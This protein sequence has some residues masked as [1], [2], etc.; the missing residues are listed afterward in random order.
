MEKSRNYLF[1]NYKVFLILTVV[2]GHVINSSYKN[3]EFLFYLKWFISAFHMPAFIL[4]TGYFSKRKTDFITLLKR[5]IVPYLV[6][7]VLYYLLY[8]YIIHRETSLS[9]MYPKYTLWF[10]LAVFFWKL[11]TPYFT[12]IPGYLLISIIAGLCIGLSDNSG[13]LLSIARITVLYPFYLIGYKWDASTISKI[14]EHK[15][16]I[17]F[18]ALTALILVLIA[19]S[20]VL[21]SLPVT[22]TYARYNYDAL[23]QTAIEGLTLRSLFYIIGFLITVSLLIIMPSKKYWFSDI[24]KVTLQ[25]YLFHGMILATLNYG[26]NILRGLS[27]LSD[28]ILLMLF[29]IGLTYILSRP[30]FT[31]LLD[32]L[33][34]KKYIK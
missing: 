4:I 25:I 11:I 34:L 30:I 22:L 13:S 27:T 21:H 10:L 24:G 5:F 3:N 19:L 2:I 15:Y 1:D 33:L 28:T 26:T 29:S 23:K 7:E 9:L 20:N 6:F 14:K 18:V 17:H 31:K 16:A 32:F 8:V 12:K